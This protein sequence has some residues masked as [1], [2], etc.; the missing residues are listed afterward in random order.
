MRPRYSPMFQNT[1]DLH[2]ELVKRFV[3]GNVVI[4]EE[5]V[6]GFENGRVIKASAIYTVEDGLITEVRFVQ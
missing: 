3:M 6:T 1:T 2:C 4:D 5:R